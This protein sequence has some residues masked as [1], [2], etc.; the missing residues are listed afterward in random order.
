MMIMRHRNRGMAGNGPLREAPGPGRLAQLPGRRGQG[1][2]DQLFGARNVRFAGGAGE[3]SVVAD[4]M[5]AKIA[6]A[7]VRNRP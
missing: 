1:R 4:V 6:I 5:S 2:S 7:I 3:Q